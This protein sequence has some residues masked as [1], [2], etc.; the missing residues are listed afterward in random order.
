MV[1]GYTGLR[2]ALLGR[3]RAW[4]GDKELELGSPQRQAFLAVLLLRQELVAS[5]ADVVED[6]WGGN[7]PARVVVVSRTYASRLR[8]LLEPEPTVGESPRVLV[9]VPDGCALHVAREAVDLARFEDHVASAGLARAA[10]QLAEARARL[11]LALEPLAGVPGAAMDAHRLGV[12]L[13]AQR[14]TA[15]SAARLT[16]ASARLGGRRNRLGGRAHPL[17]AHGETGSPPAGPRRPHSWPG[18]WPRLWR[19][20]GTTGVAPT[21]RSCSAPPL[22]DSG[23]MTAPGRTAHE[24][25]ARL[26]CRR[27]T[28]SSPCSAT[29]R[30]PGRVRTGTGPLMRAACSPR[31]PNP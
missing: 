30:V 24:I 14:R 1:T 2:F 12:V 15:E 28:I 6:L 18:P 16:E 26:V 31:V 9:S 3:L 11:R 29:S 4:R 25:C 20:S 13:N 27:P 17:P 22:A 23:T 10:A 19:R 8:K 21:R 5:V 7:P